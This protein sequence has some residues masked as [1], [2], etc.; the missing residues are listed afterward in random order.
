MQKK[1]VL[2]W[3]AAVALSATPLSLY[4]KPSHSQVRIG[5]YGDTLSIPA[6]SSC[7]VP[8]GNTISA[9][10]IH[11]FYHEAAATDYHP[12]VKELL[13]YKRTH[14]ADD[15]LYYQLVR[16]T[17]QALS[18]KADNYY[19]Y[20][21]YKWFLLCASGYDATVNIVGDKLLLYVQND[22][23]IYDIPYFK[24]DGKQYIC[25]NYHDYGYN[26]DFANMKQSNVAVSV[27]GA[28]AKFSYRLTQLPKFSPAEYH[29]KDLFFNYQGSSYR[30]KI[31]INDEVKLLFTNYPVADYKLYI[32]APLSTETYQSLIP[33]LKKQVSGLSVNNG[34]DY[35]MHFTRYAFS[36]TKD[37]DNFGR[38]KRLSP[39]QTL[40]Y[41]KS[42]CEDRAALFYCLVKEI[43]NL[44]MI[45]LTY[46]THVTVAVKLNKPKGQPIVYNGV[47]YSICEPTPQAEDLPI[48]YSATELKHVPYEVAYEYK[49]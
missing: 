16:K 19:R 25:L 38:E 4:A 12:L 28:V 5:F 6:N 43:Y 26:I 11:D 30:F 20:T 14:I 48:G 1:S 9:Q 3:L 22:E 29:E 37:Y 27:P 36:Y 8:F 13:E 33:Q 21:L 24:K 31:K 34:I 15:W 23:D 42:D 7:E 45:L 47:T 44:P 46:P 41:E 32:N 10:T 49:P 35:L 18:P 40:L 39:E 17:A 2:I